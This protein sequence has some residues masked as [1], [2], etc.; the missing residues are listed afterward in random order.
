VFAVPTKADAALLIISKTHAGN[1]RQ[2]QQGAATTGTTGTAGATEIANDPVRGRMTLVWMSGKR[3]TR[4]SGR[5]TCTRSDVLNAGFPYPTITV[6]VNATS[7]AAFPPVKRAS[8]PRCGAAMFAVKN[9][10]IVSW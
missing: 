7:N 3:W 1:Y 9:S 4:E 6:T 2:G 8:V 10:T 5:D